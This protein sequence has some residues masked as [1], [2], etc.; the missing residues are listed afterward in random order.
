MFIYRE[1]DRSSCKSIPLFAAAK[2]TTSLMWPFNVTDVWGWQHSGDT[3]HSFIHTLMAT[4]CVWIISNHHSSVPSN[5]GAAR[6]ASIH[7]NKRPAAHFS[8]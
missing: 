8:H 2:L 4:I 7:S 5:A 1:R 3:D 6:L